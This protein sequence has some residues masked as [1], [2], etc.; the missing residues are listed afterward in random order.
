MAAP[1][2]PPEV[3]I[4]LLALESS[5]MMLYGEGITTMQFYEGKINDA[6]DFL[7]ERMKEVAEAN[8]WIAARLVKDKKRHGKLVA[9]RHPEKTD[10]ASVVECIFVQNDTLQMSEDMPYETIMNI[11]SKSNAH[12]PSGHV[13]INT[14]RAV[15]SLTITPTGDNSYCV[16][17]SMSHVIGDG[18]T[19]YSLLNMLSSEGKVF[20]MEVIRNEELRNSL[21]SEV[22]EKEY[23]I[24]VNP[25]CAQIMKFLGEFIT[26][27][28]VVPRCFFIDKEKLNQAKIKAK[29]ESEAADF[30]GTNDIITSGFAKTIDTEML[31][32][33]MDFRGKLSGLS[34]EHAGCYHLGILLGREG[35]ESPNTIRKALTSAAPYSRCQKLPT[36]CCIS[37]KYSG[38]IS[39]WSSLSKGGLIIPN[40]NQTLHVPFIDAMTMSTDC[41]VVF[42]A[43]PGRVAVMVALQN[44]DIAKL[45]REIPLSEESVNEK[46][47]GE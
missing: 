40:A 5:D 37:G 18:H 11:I 36:G 47:F 20:P 12:I 22:G 27:K 19:Y 24:M 1:I 4:P 44:G 7:C 15:S 25:S 42:N 17:F 6:K 23:Q 43:K 3:D 31:T 35:Y 26:A 28:K 13:L 8:P 39:N 32:M 16:I 45:K 29:E 10:P 34:K 46:M 33:A 9:M 30:V 14:G 21:P 38:I 41:C 2:S